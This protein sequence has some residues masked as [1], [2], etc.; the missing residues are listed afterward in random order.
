[1]R[2]D[3]GCTLGPHRASPSDNGAP[4]LPLFVHTHCRV[5]TGE[6]PGFAAAHF[7]F[8]FFLIGV[9]Q[10]GGRELTQGVGLAVLVRDSEDTHYSVALLPQAAVHLLAK[11][12]LAN[13]G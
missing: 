9:D 7:F 13:Y 5:D 4:I 8:F 12:A 11:Q 3:E 6:P 2:V 1:M 10:R